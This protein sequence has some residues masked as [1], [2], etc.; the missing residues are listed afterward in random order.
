V[1]H[2]Q[3]ARAHRFHAAGWAVFAWLLLQ[4]PYRAINLWRIRR[5]RHPL[6]VRCMAA[7]NWAVLISIF[8][9]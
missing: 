9:L 3:F 2:G 8:I 5:Q 4:L 1:A 7:V 6:G